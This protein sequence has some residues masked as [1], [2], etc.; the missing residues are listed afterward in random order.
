MLPRIERRT[1]EQEQRLTSA[2]TNRRI[3]VTRSFAAGDQLVQRLTQL[4]ATVEWCP[5]IATLPPH[6]PRPLRRAAKVVGSFDWVLFTSPNAVEAFSKRIAAERIDVLALEVAVGVVGQSTAHAARAFGWNVDFVPS[7]NSGAALATALPQNLRTHAGTIRTHG[8]RVLL[9]RADIAG[10]EMPSILRERGFEVTEVVAYRTVD[11]ITDELVATLRALDTVDAIT[12]TSASTVRHMAVAAD[13]AGWSIARAQDMHGTRIVCLGN[14]T[15]DE[16]RQQ[17][18]S[19]DAI[20][21]DPSIDGLISA[22]AKALDARAG[23][24]DSEGP[25]LW[26][27]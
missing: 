2:L 19:V 4:G 3:V 13:R 22:V 26:S 23:T 6:D 12:F 25:S 7:F 20:A 11:A 24:T 15:A 14:S 17:G 9:P 18:W 10:T 27:T 16:V 1:I 8:A 21:R 5:C